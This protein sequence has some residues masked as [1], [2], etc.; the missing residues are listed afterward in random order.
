MYDIPAPKFHVG[1]KVFCNTSARVHTILE[2]YYV[3]SKEEW[4]YRAFTGIVRFGGQQETIQVSEKDICVDIN[5]IIKKM[6]ERLDAL[7]VRAID[8]INQYQAAIEEF[9][10]RFPELNPDGTLKQV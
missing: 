8:A 9:V 4:H 7:Q 6:Q 5:I 10:E 1:Q 3:S 2:S